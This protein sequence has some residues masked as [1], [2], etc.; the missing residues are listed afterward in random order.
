MSDQN[1]IETQIASGNFNP[2]PRRGKYN[3]NCWWDT[4]DRQHIKQLALL[5]YSGREALFGGGKGSGKSMAMIMLAAQYLDCRGYGSLILR[6]T[7][8]QLSKAGGLIEKA[9]QVFHPFIQSGELEW[10][11]AK[12]RI[13]SKEGGIIQFG[14]LEN[15]KDKYNY[16]G[17]EYH[18]V[19]IDQAELFLPSELMF[20]RAQQRRLSGSNI[21][22]RYLLSANPGGPAHEFLKNRYM[23]GDPDK[24]YLH[25]NMDDNPW[26]DQAEAEESLRALSSNESEYRQMR[27]GDWDIMATGDVLSGAWF[28]DVPG[29][30]IPSP[31]FQVRAWDV[32]GKIKQ[33]SGKLGDET[34]G[35]LLQYDKKN[36]VFYV[37]DQRVFRAT[38]MQVEDIIGSTMVAD[39]AQCR[40]LTVEEKPPG[41]AGVDREQRRLKRFCAEGGHYY[42]MRGSQ[43]SKTD[44]VKGTCR[45]P[46]ERA[47]SL[48]SLAQRGMVKLKTAPWNAK[49]R[50]QANT[51][52]Q[53]RVSDDCID[54]LSLAVNEFTNHLK[55][56]RV[57]LNRRVESQ[58]D[59]VQTNGLRQFLA[60]RRWM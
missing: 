4:G 6:K 57:V 39:E 53:K 20:L 47:L 25:A 24:I 34:V 10:N 55:Q 48:S 26:V 51:F 58:L 22:L 32:A 23:S 41:E 8:S 33:A 31:D 49:L 7:W 45:D 5:C 38:P 15:E 46:E 21:P 30:T 59:G 37:T 2:V 13:K 56:A 50:L 28:V 54:S 35:T 43:L 44:R 9:Q 36:G 18:F 27:W 42:V 40:T 14:H 16:Q 12:R 17:D 3:R 52:G 11:E 60:K 29:T 19:A 1:T